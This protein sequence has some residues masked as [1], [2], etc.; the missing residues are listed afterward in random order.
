MQLF[1]RDAGIVH[2]GETAINHF[3]KIVRRNIGR[4]TNG[5]TTSTVDEQIGEARRKNGRLSFRTVI[6]INEIDR[7]LV[8]IA[9]QRIGSLGKTAFGITH[10]CR[11]I[12]IHAAEIA[13]TINQR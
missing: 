13:L 2:I 12:G 10:G 11:R 8:K 5:D 6:V 3:A 4:H 9:Q 7:V 1:G